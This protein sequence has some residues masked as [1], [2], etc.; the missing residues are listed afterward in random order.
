MAPL[1]AGLAA[2]QGSTPAFIQ[3]QGRITDPAGQ[4]ITVVGLTL[5]FNLYNQPTGGAALYSELQSM[6]VTDGLVSTLVGSVTP[7]PINIFEQN[8]ELYLGVTI[9]NDA[10]AVP[11]YPLVSVPY[12]FKART[13]I[14]AEDVSG[15]D[16]NP[17]S[18]TVGG[19][20]VIDS[21]GKWVG[22]S[23]GLVGPPGPPGADGD[24][25]PAGPAGADG[26]P[27]PPGTNGPAFADD[28]PSG[29]GAVAG[30]DALEMHAVVQLPRGGTA[31]AIH[32][33]GNDPTVTFDAFAVYIPTG[34]PIPLGSGTIGTLL[35]VVD[36][37][38][39]DADYLL[40]R[41]NVT[42][43]TQRIFGGLIYAPNEGAPL[44]ATNLNS[45]AGIGFDQPVDGVS[46]AVDATPGS[47]LNGAPFTS[48]PASLNFNNGV[49]YA[50]ALG[51][52]SGNATTSVI[53]ISETTSPILSFQSKCDTD[54]VT[55]ERRLQVS[56]NGFQT[57]L[58]DL[59]LSKAGGEVWT[60]ETIP[61]N[62]I[63]GS[64]RFRF[65]FDSI[66]TVDNNHAGWF[67]DDLRVWDGAPPPAGAILMSLTP[68]HFLLSAQ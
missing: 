64:V 48:P 41:V 47:V 33:F 60:R 42:S 27:G 57:L 52:T 45:P 67:V 20:T 46:W 13:S 34:Q 12:A 18:V 53:N 59:T 11:R 26:P 29:W 1:L 24:P 50:S 17:G 54:G 36:Y 66:D 65:R 40:I 38:A 22:D 6:D 9:G 62:P 63:W 10:E 5:R 58:A 30:A 49:D 3:Y 37:T 55:D 44:F 32:L 23:T 8:D 61:L 28:T 68:R 4:P 16:I 7:L 21:S 14:E 51:P 43:A 25:G 35:D 56:N 31:S 2:A 39:S 19:M 15:Q